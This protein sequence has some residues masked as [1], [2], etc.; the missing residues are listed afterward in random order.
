[1]V[2][3]PPLWY[4]ILTD[5]YHRT[6]HPA[7]FKSLPDPPESSHRLKSRFRD[8]DLA[9]SYRN[10][11]GAVLKRDSKL[12]HDL[13]SIEEFILIQTNSAVA[14]GAPKEGWSPSDAAGSLEYFF[15]Y[16]ANE[17]DSRSDWQLPPAAD[18]FINFLSS[19]GRAQLTQVITY[20]IDALRPFS[21]N[22]PI[23]L[24]TLPLLAIHAK[25]SSAS[26]VHPALPFL[27][28]TLHMLLRSPVAVALFQELK[29][30]DILEQMYLLNFPGAI[31][32]GHRD[33]DTAR[34]EMRQVFC[35]ILG[36]LSAKGPYHSLAW[37][38]R[39]ERT[40]L[41][42]KIFLQFVDNYDDVNAFRLPYCNTDPPDDKR[43]FYQEMVGY[44]RC[45]F[46]RAHVR[47]LLTVS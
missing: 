2:R 22:E 33:L 9:Y 26:S 12:I 17:S 21:T 38:L 23:S 1:M 16:L 36:V 45:V 46:I 47:S 37:Y 39:E 14:A 11:F 41:F 32:D 29:M 18:D 6:L 10:V 40:Q 5:H 28:F 7:R 35:M 44:L 31:E 43:Q 25:L 20:I 4:S 13:F 8:D 34:S 3:V 19:G 27:W 24:P 30:L 15:D 42:V